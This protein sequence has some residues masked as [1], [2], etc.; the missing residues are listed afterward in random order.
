MNTK[1]MD[2]GD[3][4][5][6]GRCCYRC[7]PLYPTTRFGWNI[8]ITRAVTRQDFTTNNRSVGAVSKLLIADFR[9][10][11]GWWSQLMAGRLADVSGGERS[12][13]NQLPPAEGAPPK[14]ERTHPVSDN[15]FR[16]DRNPISR[17]VCTCGKRV[18]ISPTNN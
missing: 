6:R 11:V 16:K 14:K 9:W 10:R 7:I 5:N 1:A 3:T 2:W 12:E 17:M 8:L 18:T 15:P 13:P 4:P